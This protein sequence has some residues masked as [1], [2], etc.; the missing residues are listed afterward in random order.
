MLKQK[1]RIN[2][3]LYNTV[4]WSAGA[5]IPIEPDQHDVLQNWI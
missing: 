4:S 3:I 2:M 5:F 1:N